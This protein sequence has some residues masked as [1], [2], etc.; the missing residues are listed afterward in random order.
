MEKYD[1]NSRCES[2]IFNCW[3]SQEFGSILRPMILIW[4]LDER[5]ANQ[6]KFSLVESLC[7]KWFNWQELF[8][9]ISLYFVQTNFD[10]NLLKRKSTQAKQILGAQSL[11]WDAFESWKSKVYFAQHFRYSF[12]G[13]RSPELES[14]MHSQKSRNDHEF[15]MSSLDFGK[16]LKF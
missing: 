7:L 15:F 11:P 2:Y 8:C 5:P 16:Y 4:V 10:W 14:A 9:E 13:R 3:M 12:I 1:H 6:K